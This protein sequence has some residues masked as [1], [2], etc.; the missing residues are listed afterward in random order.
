[1]SEN[2][3]KE[4]TLK[5][6]GWRVKERREAMG[7]TQEQFADKYEY[8]RTTLA[9]LEAG[10]RDFKS[11][12]II[13]LAGQLKVSTDWLLGGAKGKTPEVEE[14]C[15]LTGLTPSAIERLKEMNKTGWYRG[16]H[17]PTI[18]FIIENTANKNEPSF[19][20]NM[21]YYLFHKFYFL[22]GEHP[23][24]KSVVNLSNRGDV[25]E[26]ELFHQSTTMGFT[27]DG[28]TTTLQLDNSKLNDVFLANIMQCLP[29]LKRV[30]MIQAAPG[31]TEKN[32]GSGGSSN[33]N[34]KTQ[35]K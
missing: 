16:V 15:N 10:V 25:E 18:S 30:A 7:L 33:G 11:T 13:E 31:L 9:K 29:E 23:I 20:E 14:I 26:L 8:A 1:M 28:H 2:K 24:D 19:V 6:I 27:V 17:L 4:R 34:D 12:E 21:F 35:K 5:S 3:S 32:E 22:K